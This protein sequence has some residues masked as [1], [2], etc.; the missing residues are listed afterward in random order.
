[1][2]DPVHQ[3]SDSQTMWTTVNYEEALPG[4]LTPLTWTFWNERM[5]LAQRG[6]YVDLGVLPRSELRF[7]PRADDRFVG[8]FY[9]RFAGNMS[10][11]HA[12][13]DLI[14]GTSGD[15]VERHIFG[16][17]LTTGGTTPSRRRYPAVAVR[18]PLTVVTLPRRIRQQRAAVDAWWRASIALPSATTT[19]ARPAL[20]EA[21]ARFG[22]TMRLHVL[23]S[24]LAVITYGQVAELVA[25][26]GSDGLER[27][28]T[29]GQDLEETKLAAAAWDVAKGRRSLDD[30]LAEHGYHGPGEGRLEGRV[31][32]EDP[33]P[34]EEMI[35][36]YREMSDDV[37]PGMRDAARAADRDRAEAEL[38]AAAGS[39]ARRRTAFLLGSA[40]RFVN[41]RETGKAAFLQC[42]DVARSATRVIARDLVAQ[43][44][45]GDADDVAF[46]TV[47]EL[48]AP[49]GD[50]RAIVDV[51]RE[52]HARYL[53]IEL[54][55]LW[56]GVPE[57]VAAT[58]NTGGSGSIAGIGASPGVAEGRARVVVD[59]PAPGLVPGD[60]LVCHTT[61][62]SWAP[63]FLTASAV[64]I[65]IGAALSHGA[66]VARE[67]G[68]PCVIN[69]RT[70]TRD[71]RTGDRLRV[72][73]AA[74]T[75]VVMEHRSGPA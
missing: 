72:D 44:L 21:T 18:A 10:T 12:V 45:L 6:G 20:A 16:E 24:L 67:L 39:L 51:R 37:S 53:T 50:L 31:W 25:G 64:V 74:G 36:A 28:L 55:E 59:P 38:L 17:V 34:L 27:L 69:T 49:P 5:E 48:Q 32:R 71:I 65:D 63:L 26:A 8:C 66:I 75:V 30:F 52:R 56:N 40:R 43:G 11:V 13:S 47:D 1:V 70:G 33:A 19:A 14:P 23:G 2:T 9:G 62:P 7:P 4:V 41:L 15:D 42:I 35:H 58:A 73:G 60:V 57:P 3:Q 29:T 54:P 61:D 22:A 68:I 46:L